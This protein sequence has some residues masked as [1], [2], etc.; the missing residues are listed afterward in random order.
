MALNSASSSLGRVLD[1]LWGS[2]IYDIRIESPIFSGA[3]VFLIGL[4]FSV[5]G[6]QKQVPAKMT[7]EHKHKIKV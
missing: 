7:Q 3:C 4:V 6:L 1:P 5:F 2:D